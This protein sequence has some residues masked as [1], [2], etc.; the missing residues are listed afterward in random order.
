[1][2]E[3]TFPWLTLLVAVPAVS[4]ALVRAMRR[5]EPA[6]HVA[7]GSLAI[8]LLV[9]V[10]AAAA[11]LGRGH[12]ADPWLGTLGGVPLLAVDELS[13]PLLPFAALLFAAVALVAPR[14]RLGT[15]EEARTLAAQAIVLAT[16]CARDP[17]V[18]AALWA[19][20]VL[21]PLLALRARGPATAGAT[22]VFAL[23]MTLAVG[24][25]GGGAVLLAH[26]TP[27]S[28]ATIAGAAL[29]SVA[30]LIRKGI[31]PLHSWLPLLMERAPMS[32]ATLF[33]VPQIGAYAFVRLVLP[34][35]SPELLSV[36]ADLALVTAVYGA[37][38]GL[39][40]TEA[41]RAFG[42][43]FL[44]ESALVLAGLEGTSH[45]ALT[46]AL[47]V[48]IACGLALTGFGMTLR[49]L[50]ARRGDLSLLRFHGGYRRTPLLAASFLLLGL[51][52]VGFPGTLGFIGVELLIDG[53]VSTHPVVGFALV[54]AAALNGITVVR[55]YG[56]LFAGARDRTP[57]ALGLR[58]RELVGL[59][60]L[61]TLLLAAGL[62]PRPV[63]HS[64]ARAATESL[65][66]PAWQNRANP[67]TVAVDPN[68]PP[69]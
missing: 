30:V 13:A 52:S 12:L 36:V 17:R 56:V 40:Q 28:T 38:L 35:A 33:S 41:R 8:T 9:S 42:F 39:T 67:P 64:R 24:T 16:Y 66:R 21:P 50:E 62:A 46:G 68:Q 43:L 55:M 58:R 6:R 29:V 25:F 37:V 34:A 54:L 5:P 15:R 26:A 53:T 18:L 22:R 60:T 44:S 61:V 7:L 3:L 1:M 59:L 45:T 11:S 32:L 48:W 4:A 10:G 47:V 20:S 65:A 49:L 31:L 63:V 57:A 69:P 19:L 27:G 14:T 2:G 51:A 23:Y